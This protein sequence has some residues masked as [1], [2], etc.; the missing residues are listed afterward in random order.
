MVDS[1][2]GSEH[3]A[4]TMVNAL[5][6]A[7]RLLVAVSARSLASVEESLTLPQFRMLV[8]LHTRGSL[9]LSLLAAEL[10]V[11][12]ST[13][14]RMIDRLVIAAMVTRAPAPNDRRTSSIS[15]TDKGRVTVTRATERRR[16]EIARIVD[17]MDPPRREDLVRAL[18]AFTEAG[19]EPSVRAAAPRHLGW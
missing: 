19:S 18:R 9:S 6:T 7:S 3:D 4:D 16:A 17:A 12:P 15:L 11:Q 14:M 8:A 2:A 10:D 5:L 1:S 13:A